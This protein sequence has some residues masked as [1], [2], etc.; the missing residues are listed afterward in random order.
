M[1][2]IASGALV[3]GSSIGLSCVLPAAWGATGTDTGSSSDSPPVLEEVVVTAGKVAEPL[4]SVAAPI[5]AITESRL[6]DLQAINF[7]DYAKLVPGLSLQENKPGQTVLTLQGISSFS[8]GSTVGL[9]VDDTPYGSS[10]GLTNGQFY[11]GDLN[12]YDLARVE[13]LKGPQGTLYG[14]ST[15]GGLLKFVTNAPDPARFAADTQLGT[16]TTRSA[17]GWSVKGMVNLP[18]TDIAALRVSGVHEKDPGFIN[19]PSRR[20]DNINS[21]EEDGVRAS[22]LVKPLDALTIRL[23]A[24]G[25]VTVYNDNDAVDARENPATGQ[26]LIPLQPLTGDLQVSQN[27]PQYTHSRYR[28]YDA[29]V[30]WDFGPA[31]LVSTTSYG[32]LQQA[33]Q[34]DDSVLGAAPSPVVQITN[35]DLEKLTQELRLQSTPVSQPA[36]G[37][38]DWLAGAYF[39]RETAQILPE[40][41]GT[42]GGVLPVGGSFED[43]ASTYKEEAG[44]LN[45][46]YHF[47]SQF[48]VGVGGRYAHN[49][50]TSDQT[51]GGPLYAG[52]PEQIGASSQGLA[53]YSF[54]PRWK[55]TRDTT[56][57]A[58]VASGFRP[59][60]PNVFP[61]GL[62]TVNASSTFK[63]DRVV[64][65][66]LGFR[67]EWLDHRLALDVSAF[68]IHWREIQLVGLITLSNGMQT[69][70]TQN[71]G[72]AESRGIEW[73]G[74][75]APVSGLTLSLNGAFTDAKLTQ[76]TTADVGG[77]NGD[78]LPY[79]P[80]WTSALDVNYEFSVGADTRAF[81]GALASYVG[82]QR[83]AF[84]SVLAFTQIPLDSYTTLDLR[85]GVRHDQWTA[86]FFCKNATDQRGITGL[87]TNES[88]N[89][90]ADTSAAFPQT[91]YVIR[92]RTFGI[93]LGVR[94]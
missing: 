57:Y 2:R 94:F 40:V 90:A 39:T 81:A 48:D 53:L 55:P 38:L 65:T 86:E 63:P 84:S 19:D 31:A 83:T 68:D 50:Q 44:F 14:A 54:A 1:R 56:V 11:T 75:F 61:V 73:Q 64:S 35:F 89:V 49:K 3:V 51:F 41:S 88:A 27:V 77:F 24:V 25:Q 79:V 32:T 67:T 18:V 10:S 29:S 20:L 45:L 85:L 66:D 52:L 59:G 80:R 23:T 28:V 4:Q 87:G 36:R 34:T 58:R 15:L 71:G 5:T 37:E 82:K 46:T 33:Q 21:S 13:V 76:D 74:T 60:G 62:A 70:L 8:G 69:S 7:A 12:T 92:P 43:L 6:E 78:P 17:W 16:E 91:V 47:T 42:V 9:Y 93:N 72:T 22:F 30:N 26:V